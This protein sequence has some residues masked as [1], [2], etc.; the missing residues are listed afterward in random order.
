MSL[1]CWK[2]ANSVVFTSENGETWERASESNERIRKITFTLLLLELPFRSNIMTTSEK[3]RILWWWIIEWISYDNDKKQQSL[4]SKV[5]KEPKKLAMKQDFSGRDFAWLPFANF[6]WRWKLRKLLPNVSWMR[7]R[8][9]CDVTK[10]EER[11]GS[12]Q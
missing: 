8:Y 1:N 7:I 11:W 2:W 10:K 4:S 3:D 9:N 12:R 5:A 6:P